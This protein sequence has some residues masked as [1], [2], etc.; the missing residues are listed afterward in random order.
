[1]NGTY[2]LQRIVSEELSSSGE[3]AAW[4]GTPNPFRLAIKSLPIF[5]FSIP[6]TAFALFWVYAA[7]GFSFPPDFSEGG[8]SYFPLFGLPFV[9]IGFV[10]F[11]SP[12]FQYFKAFRTIYIITNKTVK[13]LS[14]G[15][16]KKVETYSPSDFK[17]FER[18]ERSD[19]SGDI[20]FKNDVSVNSRGTR[21]VTPIGFFGVQ[22]VRIVEQHL[23]NLR[24]SVK[25][26]SESN[27]PS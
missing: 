17:F 20:I 24:Q 6:W 10:M 8:F 23:I 25:P 9:I 13:V 3:S 14:T 19:G 4:F 11:F 12:L 7:S 22:Q 15:R 1:M 5:I 26:L 27:E 21:T 16:T 2:D 18:K